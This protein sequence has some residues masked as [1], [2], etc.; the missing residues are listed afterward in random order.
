VGRD[1]AVGQLA[2]ER[3]Y[4]LLLGCQLEVHRAYS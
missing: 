3:L 4:L 1:L 2:R